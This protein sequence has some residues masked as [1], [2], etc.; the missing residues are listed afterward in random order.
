[1]LVRPVLA[2]M[3]VV[4]ASSGI[5]APASGSSLSRRDAATTFDSFDRPDAGTLGEAESGEPWESFNGLWRISSGAAVFEPGGSVAEATVDTG[6]SDAFRAD[7]DITLS[8]TLHRANA[9]I[10]I[11]HRNHGNHVFCKVEVTAGHPNG[12]MSIGTYVHGTGTS[13]FGPASYEDDLGLRNGRTYHVACRREGDRIVWTIAGGNLAERK[14][15][16]Y[17]LTPDDIAAFGDAT[18][19]GLRARYTFDEDDGGSRWEDFEVSRIDDA[20]R[21]AR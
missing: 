8:P 16:H 19:Q 2:A 7:A 1:M 9:G 15:V 21:R 11:L 17:L 14:H 4:L 5:A 18:S 20:A 10:T 13:L 6:L 12:F 3:F